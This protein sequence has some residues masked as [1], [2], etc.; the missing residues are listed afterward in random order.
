MSISNVL[1]FIAF[2]GASLAAVPISSSMA[3]EK[4]APKQKIQTFITWGN[5]GGNGGTLLVKGYNAVDT[6]QAINC[7]NASGCTIEIDS[8]VGVGYGNDSSWGI[9]A[10]IDGA[11]VKT[12]PCWNQSSIPSNGFVTGNSRQNAQVSEGTH[13]VQTEVIVLE[14]AYLEDWQSNYTLYMP[15]PN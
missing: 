10:V 12:P 8:M 2:C 1:L 4:G 5:P 15:S 14:N 7:T 9:C 13:T 3:N 11:P 6:P